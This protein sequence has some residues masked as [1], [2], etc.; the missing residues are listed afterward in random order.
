MRRLAL[1]L[2]MVLATVLACVGVAKTEPSR[3]ARL[4]V[5]Q[6]GEADGRLRP[7]A[8]E[9]G[10]PTAFS[11]DVVY[12][13]PVVFGLVLAVARRMDSP[14]GS[15]R[16]TY[17]DGRQSTVWTVDRQGLARLASPIN[18]MFRAEGVAAPAFL[19][20]LAAYPSG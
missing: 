16:L 6:T 15:F 5:E 1:V 3:R 20:V 7:F 2:A 17:D 9:V 14:G 10:Q 13:K 19:T 18:A 4:F 12:V 8:I 11:R